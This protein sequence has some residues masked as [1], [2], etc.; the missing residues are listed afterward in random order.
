MDQTACIDLPSF[1]LQLLLRKH[2]DWREHPAAVVEADTPQGAILWINEKARVAGIRT[3]MRYAAGLS[4]AAGLRAA[5]VTPKDIEDEV[6]QLAEL[7]RRFT[8]FVEP[9]EDE[10]GVFWLDAKGL[11]RLFGSLSEWA[12]SLHAELVRAGFVA[13]IAV[14]FDR[15]AVYAVAKD[16]RKGDSPLFAAKRHPRSFVRKRGLSP[17][18]SSLT[19]PPPNAQRRARFVSTGYRF[20]LR[21]ATHS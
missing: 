19:H 21:R 15:F 8:P 14:G 11:E 10:P 7:L 16:R 17:F 6:A 2:P 5:V 4:L 20:R 12:S 18:R 13:S 3:G 9:G 1:P